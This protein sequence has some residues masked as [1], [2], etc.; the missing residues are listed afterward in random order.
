MQKI[1]YQQ[2]SNSPMLRLIKP[3]SK[4]DMHL[5][6]MCCELLIAI[7]E[8]KDFNPATHGN[9]NEYFASQSEPNPEPNPKR[10]SG[11]M[12]K[13]HPGTTPTIESHSSTLAQSKPAGSEMPTNQAE[14]GNVLG[15]SDPS[16]YT[17]Q[18]L[19]HPHAQTQQ[20]PQT[21]FQQMPPSQ[22]Q[23]QQ[24]PPTQQQNQQLPPPSQ[25]QNIQPRYQ[26]NPGQ[27]PANLTHGQPERSGQMPPQMAPEN[28]GQREF[29]VPSQGPHQMQTNPPQPIPSQHPQAY[30]IRP[31]QVPDVVTQLY[32][33]IRGLLEKEIGISLHNTIPGE[34]IYGANEC[35]KLA[36]QD[37]FSHSIVCDI[38]IASLKNKP[39]KEVEIG[40]SKLASFTL[41]ILTDLKSFTGNVFQ[42]SSVA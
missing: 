11:K 33:S 13:P 42:V 8:L 29:N 22:T 38:I 2:D 9:P 31:R 14:R 25:A 24:M 27:T 20:L 17:S 16:N 23:F 12:I 21:Q 34:L 32:S 35:L 41:N 26:Q 5:M 39:I 30:I 15:T 28:T 7:Q 40:L 6:S 36:A 19:P 37:K 18:P 4:Q 3:D 1:G 10:F